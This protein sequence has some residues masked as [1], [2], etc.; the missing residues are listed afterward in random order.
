MECTR[1]GI[2]Q[3]IGAFFDYRTMKYDT[4]CR[5][6]RALPKRR[7][8]CEN[9]GKMRPL[10]AFLQTPAEQD[11]MAHQCCTCRRKVARE[12]TRGRWQVEGFINRR[13]KGSHPQ[14]ECEACH[15]VFDRRRMLRH[16]C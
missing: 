11:Y 3:A 15:A 8:L 12:W 7:R 9:C 6:C 16:Q 5:D 1:C 2:E 13:P 14:V 4:V 10:E